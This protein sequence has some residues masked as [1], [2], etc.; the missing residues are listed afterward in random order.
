LGVV[1]VPGLYCRRFLKNSLNPFSKG[2]FERFL[3]I[4]FER[5]LFIPFEKVVIVVFIGT[6]GEKFDSIN[7]LMEVE[8]EMCSVNGALMEL[9]SENFALMER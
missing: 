3:F 5:L 7:A 9:S 2:S 1:P 8:L 6:R 4:L